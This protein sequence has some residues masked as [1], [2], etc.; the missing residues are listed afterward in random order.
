MPQQLL[1]RR[2]SEDLPDVLIHLTSR[3]GTPSPGVPQDIA[4]LF[5]WDRVVSILHSAS[6]RYSQPFDTR[7]PVVSFTQS[8]RRALY[9]LSRFV[10]VAFHKQAVWDAGGGPAYYVRG[11]QWTAWQDSSLPEP[12]RSMGVRLWPGWDGPPELGT[13][14]RF[15]DQT[16]TRSE[17]LHEREWRLPSPNGTDWGWAFP[18][19]AVAFLLFPN[20]SVRDSALSTLERWG[21][22]VEWVAS[23]PVAWP[24]G[25]NRSFSGVDDLWI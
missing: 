18:R 20:G 22:D 24:D 3:W 6:V 8:T 10:G 16:G 7:W 15:V 1:Q 4:S 13:G 2:Q 21:G 17:W 12:M 11:D 5:P 14:A 25:D 23:L 9:G 19:E